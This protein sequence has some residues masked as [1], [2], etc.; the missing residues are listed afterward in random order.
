MNSSALNRNQ[1]GAAVKMFRKIGEISRI[2]DLLSGFKD[3]RQCIPLI[4]GL[5]G[6]SRPAASLS[7]LSVPPHHTF[8]RPLQVRGAPGSVRV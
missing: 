2:R 3:S 4:I 8:N 5:G 1:Q 7:H 6:Q